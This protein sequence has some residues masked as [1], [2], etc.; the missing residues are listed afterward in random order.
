MLQDDGKFKAITEDAYKQMLDTKS[1]RLFFV[2]EVIEIKGNRFKVKK[3]TRKDL[4]L[5]A[6]PNQK[7]REHA[8]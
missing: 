7:E 2:G 1:N 6:I 5:R 3:I 8:K 4:V